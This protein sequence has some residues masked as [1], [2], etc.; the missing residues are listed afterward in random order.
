MERIA[1][2]ESEIEGLKARSYL[3]YELL[4]QYR[5]AVDHSDEVIADLETRLSLQR[6]LTVCIHCF[7][8]ITFPFFHVVI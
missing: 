6:T 4:M 3:T 7:L 2:L 5:T 8:L 1:S